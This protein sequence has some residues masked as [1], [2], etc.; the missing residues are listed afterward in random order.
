[1]DAIASSIRQSAGFRPVVIAP[2][3]NNDATLLDV[4]SRVKAL[5]LPLIVVDDGSTD[6]TAQR[7]AGWLAGHGDGHTFVRTHLRN[8]GKAQALLTGFVAAAQLG[9]THAATIDTDGQLDPEEIPL[10]LDAARRQ[11]LALVLGYRDERAGDYPQQRRTGRRFGNL[12]IRMT[13]GRRVRDSQC[14]LR[15]YPLDLVRRVRCR[16]GRYGYENEII[17][18]AVWA[19]FPLAEQPVHCRYLPQDQRVSHYRTWRD[20]LR[21]LRLD[22]GLMGRALLP[23]PHRRIVPGELGHPRQPL[24]GSLKHLLQWFSPRDLWRQVHRDTEDRMSIAAGVTFGA[25]IACLP[26]CGYQTL[27]ALYTARRLHLHP[28]ATVLGSHLSIPPIGQAIWLVSIWLGHLLTTGRFLRVGDLDLA[29][30]GPA[31]TAGR[32]LLAWSLG[33]I[34]VGIA[35]A[36]AVFF[37]TLGALRL[38]PPDQ[39]TDATADA[40]AD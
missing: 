19:G 5:S 30:A 33:S 28:V 11:P 32:L 7:L 14:G 16:A 17:T 20:T 8:R 1:M 12:G 25:F 31:S 18:R 22:F 40:A 35:V 10:L 24:R 36:P 13:C 29:R 37:A 3:Y 2:T 39:N 4:L 34:L 6:R 38:V 9:Y 21:L 27:L 23:W 26:A 15:V